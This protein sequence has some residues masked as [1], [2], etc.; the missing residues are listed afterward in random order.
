MPAALSSSRPVASSPGERHVAV[1][2]DR[3]SNVRERR[4]GQLLDLR[5]LLLGPG[6]IG[7]AELAG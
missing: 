6:R 1:V 7:F 4:S 2:G 5:D 3:G